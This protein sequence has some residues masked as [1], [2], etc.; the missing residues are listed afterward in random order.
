MERIT[1][2]AH[3]LIKDHIN[4]SSV[5]IDATCGNGNDTFFLANIVKTGKILAYDIQDIAIENTKKLCQEFTNIEYHH[6]SFSNIEAKGLDL[7]LFNLGYLPHGDKSVL[8]TKDETIKTLKKLTNNIELNPNIL[9]LVVVYPKHDE[10]SLE[11]KAILKFCK[12]LDRNKYDTMIIQPLNKE[13]S[14]YIITIR[15]NQK[16]H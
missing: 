12:N 10:G 9:I 6:E 14:P 2:I 3:K 11:S 7:V 5:V 8:T 1:D 13:L 16:C 4:S 15:Y